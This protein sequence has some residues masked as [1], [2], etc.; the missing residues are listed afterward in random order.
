MREK[1]HAGG[2]TFSG[3][4]FLPAVCVLFRCVLDGE[5]WVG[6]WVG[7][8]VDAWVCRCVGGR[9]GVA[10]GVHFFQKLTPPQFSRFLIKPLVWKFAFLAPGAQGPFLRVKISKTQCFFAFYD[11][12]M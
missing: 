7:R 4:S 12:C 1:S 2:V 10:G 5:R 6:G 8:C 11:F 9:G 3:A